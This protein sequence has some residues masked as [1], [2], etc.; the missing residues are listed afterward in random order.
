M[1][2]IAAVNIPED[3]PP[4]FIHLF[5]NNIS[6]EK[7]Q[8]LA[9]FRHKA[10]LYRSLLGDILIRVIIS[11]Q[12]AVNSRD[13]HFV[14]NAYGKPFLQNGPAISFNLSHS[15]NW[16]AAIF[17]RGHHCLGIDIEKIVPFPIDDMQSCFTKTENE[18]LLSKT[19]RDQLDYFFQLWTLKESC[20]KAIGKGL[21]IP[22]TNFSLEH[23]SGN[24]WRS[25]EAETFYFK[26]FRLDH[27]HRLSACAGTDDL[28]D[29][30][31]CLPVQ[32]LYDYLKNYE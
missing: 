24:N 22:L 21:S 17:G 1:L 12:T 14:A 27:E 26:S 2:T 5:L 10:D 15:G 7:R 3:L 19:G 32:H 20:V 13:I 6:P 31:Y 28:P 25:P 29:H 30:V 4:D 18:Q 8:K 16:A 9:K 11:G 23:E